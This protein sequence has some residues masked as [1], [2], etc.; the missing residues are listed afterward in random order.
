MIRLDGVTKRFG[1]V[2]AVE[3]GVPVRRPRRGRRAPRPVRLREDDAPPARR[4]LRATRRRDGRD[5]RPRRRRSPGAWVPPERA[6]NRH[7]LPGLRALP[8]P[9]GRR[10]RRLRACAPSARDA[11]RRS[12]SRSSGWPSS[13]AGT[14][15]SSRAASSSASRSP[16]RSRRRRKLVLLDE[17]WSNVDPFLRESLRTEVV[18]IIRPLGVTA[19]PRH[20]RSRG[21]VLARGP[22]RADA[23][24]H[25][26]PGGHGGGARTS[27]P[28]TR[29]AAEFVGARTS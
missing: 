9:H 3:R 20:P 11:R 5:R 23:R 2:T 1:D 29:W 26:R 18:E 28:A 25:D 15:T 22:H 17:P 4:G 7:G 27:R 19:D 14:R 12:C 13:A 10:E 16:G 6:P 24:R 21:G 8:P